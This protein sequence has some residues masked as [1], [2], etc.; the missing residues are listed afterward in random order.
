MQRSINEQRPVNAAD[1]PYNPYT[2]T[3]QSVLNYNPATTPN[4]YSQPTY[5]PYKPPSSAVRSATSEASHPYIYTPTQA[6]SSIAPVAPPLPAPVVT[7]NRPKTANAYDPPLLPKK[8]RRGPPPRPEYAASLVG[9][10]ARSVSAYER[11]SS[12]TAPH[13][14]QPAPQPQS[15]IPSGHPMLVAPPLPPLP[16]P[17]PP[18]PHRQVPFHSAFNPPADH[19]P[20]GT[21]IANKHS[22]NYVAA[23]WLGAKKSVDGDMGRVVHANLDFRSSFRPTVAEVHAHVPQQ[24]VAETNHRSTV[25]ELG[26]SPLPDAQVG[27]RMSS[28]PHNHAPQ[29][30]VHQTPRTDWVSEGSGEGVPELTAHTPLSPKE[31][32]FATLSSPRTHTLEASSQITNP[33]SPPPL[34]GS[35]QAEYTPLP[36]NGLDSSIPKPTRPDSAASNPHDPHRQ[37]SLSPASAS[38]HHSNSPLGLYSRGITRS[39]VPRASSADISPVKRSQSHELTNPL[40]NSFP[41]VFLIMIGSLGSHAFSRTQI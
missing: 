28:H 37:R 24:P 25:E 38:S 3:S 20:D 36:S 2:T 17:P 23:T 7:I 21:T 5:D 4:T 40:A 10:Q 12:P 27:T 8:S 15:N 35:N 32:T 9:Q 34:P 6:L 31:N 1:P 41:Y 30:N 16:P 11:Y 26:Y 39:P 22:N 29:E 14:T 13:A 33:L 19:G 18:P